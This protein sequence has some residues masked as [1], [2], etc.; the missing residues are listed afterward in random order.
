MVTVFVAVV[1]VSSAAADAAVVSDT[2]VTLTV[3]SRVLTSVLV[4]VS[5]ETDVVGMMDVV[6]DDDLIL[7]GSE[8]PAR[9]T[10]VVVL[11]DCNQEEL[12]DASSRCG[13]AMFRFSVV[14]NTNA[15]NTT[16][17]YC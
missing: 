12:I 17:G 10:A 8:L 2:V 4:F 16:H 3:V 9:L 1:A 15:I 5:E 11:D 7:D 14:A 6:A 13:T